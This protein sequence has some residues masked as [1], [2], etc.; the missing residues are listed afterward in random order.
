MAVIVVG[1]MKPTDIQAS[2]EKQFSYLPNDGK[3]SP[4]PISEIPTTSGRDKVCFGPRTNNN[5]RNSN[6][7]WIEKTMIWRNESD[8]KAYWTRIFTFSLLSDRISRSLDY[9][10]A[11]VQEDQS[12]NDVNLTVLR[13]RFGGYPTKAIKSMRAPNATSAIKAC[14]WSS[15]M[16]GPTSLRGMNNGIVSARK[17]A[18]RVTSIGRRIIFF[19]SSLCPQKIDFK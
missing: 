10:S 2:I 7:L 14:K 4:R 13:M 9:E 18:L 19:G 5:P 17:L 12:L 8:L 11:S 6:P 3:L 1:D 15:M 16:H